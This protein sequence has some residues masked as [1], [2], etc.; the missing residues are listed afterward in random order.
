MGGSGR[1][2]KL[3]ELRRCAQEATSGRST[4]ILRE[5]NAALIPEREQQFRRVTAH[6][7]PMAQFS[8]TTLAIS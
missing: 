6:N 4:M 7:A 2:L 5:I 8:S 1:S 3:P